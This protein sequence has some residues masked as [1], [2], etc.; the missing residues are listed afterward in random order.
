MSRASENLML[1]FCVGISV[2]GMLLVIIW[3]NI[4]P[5]TSDNL[6]WRKPLIGSLFSLICIMGSLASI[7]PSKC[8]EAF[9]FRETARDA[10]T[11]QILRA[12]HHPDCEAFSRHVVRLKGHARCAACTGLLLG[13]I[14]ALA[15]ALLYFS[16]VIQI[17]NAGFLS[18]VG[19]IAL[20]A[21]FLELRFSGYVRL[22]SNFVFVLGAFLCLVGVDQASQSI[23]IDLFSVVLIVFWIFTR[24]QLSQ[25]NHSRICDSCHTQCRFGEK[26]GEDN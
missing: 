3:T 16:G 9:H 7:F 21:G 18:S 23:A 19:V 11:R 4:P 1:A 15:G 22:G 26:T 20:L 13:A 24:I 6:S 8:S 14:V 5:S 17:E 10:A 2:F 25:W 12:S